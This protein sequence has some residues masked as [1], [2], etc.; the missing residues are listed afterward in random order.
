MILELKLEFLKKLW[1]FVL[2]MRLY[3]LLDFSFYVETG[4]CSE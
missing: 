3:K 2:P 1:I 4:S